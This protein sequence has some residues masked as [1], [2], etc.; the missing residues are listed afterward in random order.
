VRDRPEAGCSAARSRLC[1]EN[2]G[3]GP[4]SGAVSSLEEQR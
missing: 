3:H 2:L 4:V 1:A